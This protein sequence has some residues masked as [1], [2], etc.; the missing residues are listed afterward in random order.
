MK[1]IFNPQDAAEWLNQGKI[2][3]H[4]TEGVWGIGCDA[5]NQ[6][7]VEKVNILK[8]RDP[9]KS[10]ILLAPST[11]KALQYF[12]PLSEQQIEFIKNH[13]PGHTTII[14]TSNDRAPN[15]LKATDNTIAMR[16]SDH[17]P[18]ISL[19]SLFNNLMVSTSA[20]IS[21][22]PTPKKLE[23]IAE[24]FSDPDVAFYY[25]ENGKLKKPSSII[26]L[27]TMEYIRE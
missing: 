8:Q 23:D 25:Y 11:Q 2:L 5:S 15:Y 18:I 16:V 4:P 20:N 7:A 21:N 1:K 9:S 3:I 19:L 6:S 14:F 27:N 17:K 22:L 26:D 24:I 10:F 12:Q 13:W